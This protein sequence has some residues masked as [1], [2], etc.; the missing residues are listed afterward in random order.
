MSDNKK[1]DHPLLSATAI[2][3]WSGW[4]RYP[5]A[6]PFT[7]AELERVQ[8]GLDQRGLVLVRG[9]RACG[10]TTLLRQLASRAAARGWDRRAILF[11]DLEDPLWAP[12]P[13][14]AGLEALL[15]ERPGLKLVLL[16]GVERLAGWADWARRARARRRLAVAAAATGPVAG[17]APAGVAAVD[18]LPLTLD[19]WIGEYTDSKVEGESAR[20]LLDA[21]LRA[22]GLPVERSAEG[23]RRSLIE[24]FYAGLMQDVLLRQRVRDAN[25]LTAM[26]VYLLTQTGRPVSASRLKGSLTRSVD[27]ARRFLAHLEAAGLIHLVAR[28]E[29]RSR[30]NQAARLCFAAD[31]GLAWALRQTP[32]AEK[33]DISVDIE[34][35]TRAGLAWTAV[36]HCALRAGLRPWAWRARNRHGLVIESGSRLDLALDLQLGRA[37]P[38]LRPLGQAMAD[39]GCAAG[40][41]LTDGAGVG[42]RA[43]AGPGSI[44][45]RHLADWLLSPEL[46]SKSVDKEI[47]PGRPARPQSRR[48]PR[49]LL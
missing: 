18:C 42:D 38:D 10:K 11:V 33:D 8:L 1:S 30:P 9:A 32:L 39:C 25:I 36:L 13:S 3:R 37:E 29:D 19:A 4:D 14:V 24:V 12:Q 41:L 23:R 20:R 43:L 27:Q 46:T 40:L 35:P 45:V 28:L 34:M 17:A 49:H 2:A 31:T 26:A 16:D 7:R 47:S 6:R 44:A 22:G 15:A 5:G 21:Y 48:L